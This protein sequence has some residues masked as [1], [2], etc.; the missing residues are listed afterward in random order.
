VVWYS[1]LSL[2]I[3]HSFL[4]STPSKALVQSMKQMFF[5]N[6]LAFSMI[7]WKSIW[8]L[9]PLPFLNP[10]WKSGSSQFMYCWSLQFNSVTQLCPT[11]WDPMDC[12]TPGLPVHHQLLEVKL[13]LENFEHY[14]ASVWDECI[15]AIVWTFFGIAFLCDWNE[16]WPFPVPWPQLKVDRVKSKHWNI[17]MYPWFLNLS[18]HHNHPGT[19]FLRSLNPM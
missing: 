9:V 16:N 7:Q 18:V 5:W 2:R 14:F 1:H 17:S 13:S 3:F 19:F 8:S 11:L 15:C 4:W 10:S 12:S 6:Y